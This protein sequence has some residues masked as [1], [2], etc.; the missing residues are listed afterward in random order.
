MQDL[1]R[2]SAR[3]LLGFSTESLWDVL[4]GTFVLVFDDGIELKTND[5]E[6]CFSS[7]FWEFHRKYPKTPLL[8]THHVRS[9][10]NGQA[11]NTKTHIQMLN[12]VY[13]TVVDTYEMRTPAE[14]D[15][16]TR[17]VYEVTNTLYVEMI[18]RAEASVTSIDILDLIEVVEHPEIKPVLEAIHRGTRETETD[19]GRPTIEAAYATLKSVLSKSPTLNNNALAHAY[20]SKTVNENQVMQCVGPRGFLTHVDGYLMPVPVTESYTTGMGSLYNIMAESQSAAKSLYFS[21][22]PLQ[23]SEYFARRLQLMTMVVERLHYVDCGSQDYF[24]WQVKPAI[25]DKK[26]KQI[27]PGDIEFMEGK[28]YLDET[29][30]SLKEIKKTDTHLFG[31]RI[32]LRTV[33]KCKHPDPHGVCAVCFGKLSD[34]LTAEQN[35]GHVCAATMTQQTSQSVLSTKHLDASSNAAVVVLGEEGKKFFTVG[36]NGNTILLRNDLDAAIEVRL[37]VTQKEAFALTDIL[38]VQQVDQVNA[39]RVS[40]IDYVGVEVT[41][42]GITAVIPVCVSQSGRYAMLTLDFLKY[43]KLHHWT[44]DNRGNFIFDMKNW[45]TNKPIFTLPEVEYSFSAHSHQVAKI[46]ESSMEA[47]A[48]RAKP[49]APESTLVE[50]FD[51]VNAKLKVNM[52]ALEV[53]LYASMVNNSGED[54][55]GL[56]RGSTT[57]S[58]GVSDQT[59]RNRSL[60]AAYSYEKQLMLITDPQSFYKQNR[61]DSVFDVF[62]HPKEVIENRVKN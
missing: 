30:N 7:F 16:V 57:A 4:C 10:L 14:R 26:G 42:K 53:I 27:Y 55:F 49:N 9:L 21:E 20:R 38:L 39:S 34:N 35:L 24:H 52:A 61:P 62:I 43:L 45:D 12:R 28:F 40:E 46:I 50:L 33:L 22:S 54:D 59:L 48:D 31:K 6:T 18:K 23:D 11:L 29:T 1:K 56:A 13:W 37:M 44:S 47:I 17:M 58:L 51:L 25:L 2:L 8:S 15:Q 41:Q 60:S 32:L 5:R 19:Y 3:H 36:K